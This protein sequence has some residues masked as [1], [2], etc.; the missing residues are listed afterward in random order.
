M[1][2]VGFAWIIYVFRSHF[3]GLKWIVIWLYPYFFY[4][5]WFCLFWTFLQITS[6][7]A[8]NMWVKD[9]FQA[10]EINEARPKGKGL[11]NANTSTKCIHTTP[12][13]EHSQE[14]KFLNFFPYLTFHFS[15][16]FIFLVFLM[17]LKWMNGM[18]KYKL[19]ST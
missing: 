7:Q 16:F 5:P 9:Y 2:S 10:M 14:F 4:D 1:I 11:N 15:F 12:K 17:K 13:Q 8:E 6:S 18:E 19:T 3:R